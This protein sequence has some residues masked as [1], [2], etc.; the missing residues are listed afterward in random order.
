MIVV[1]ESGLNDNNDFKCQNESFLLPWGFSQSKGFQKEITGAGLLGNE[2]CFS[3]LPL[4]LTDI[5]NF[6]S[7]NKRVRVRIKTLP[8]FFRGIYFKTRFT[9]LRA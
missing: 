9:T 2:R 5:P 1:F 3:E 4:I 8:G 6:N 7:Y